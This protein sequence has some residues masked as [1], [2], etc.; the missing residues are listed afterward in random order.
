MNIFKLELCL[1]ITHDSLTRAGRGKNLEFNTSM[2]VWKELFKLS[3]HPKGQNLTQIIF[4]IHV[5][6][7]LT[8]S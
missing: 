8:N 3:N 4:L 6:N 7:H 2:K 1:S 5:Q